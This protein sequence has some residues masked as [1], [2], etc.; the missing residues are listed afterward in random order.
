MT[1]ARCVWWWTTT[2]AGGWVGVG[3]QLH[4]RPGRSAARR[5]AARGSGLPPAAALE[6]ARSHVLPC[7]PPPTPPA[8]RCQEEAIAAC[9]KLLPAAHRLFRR[10]A[11]EEDDYIAQPKVGRLDS[12]LA[13]LINERTHAPS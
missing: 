13:R 8:C 1:R 4:G 2:A 10:V 7:V 5:G 6:Q 11:G 9:Y 12:W 3:A